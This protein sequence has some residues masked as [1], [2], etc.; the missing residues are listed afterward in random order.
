MILEVLM[1]TYLPWLMADIVDVGIA[2]RDFDYVLKMGG[3]MVIIAIIGV[4]GGIGGIIFSTLAGQYFGRDVRSALFNKVQALSFS[5]LDKF[6]KASIVTRLTNDVIQVQ[7][8]VMTIILS[9]MVRASLLIIGGIVMAYKLNKELAFI[10]WFIIPLIVFIMIVIIKKGIPLF[11][12]SQEKLDQLNL[13]V[14]ENLAGVRVVKVFMGETKEKEKFGVANKNLKEI[15]IKTFK[16]AIVLSPVSMTIMNLSIVAVLWFGGI[17]VSGGSVSVGVIMAYINYLTQILI[18]VT[19]LCNMIVSIS[20]GKVSADR[21]NEILDTKIDIIN[22]ETPVDKV[23]A[24]GEVE[25]ENVMFRY[26]ESTGNPVLINISL[27]VKRGETVG[28]LG[29]TGAGKTSLVSL[30]PRL[31]DVAEG[32]VLVNGLDVREYD[33]EDL[34]KRIGFVLQQSILFTGTIKENIKWGNPDA[35]DD[36]VEAAAR[37]AQCHDFIAQQ[38]N[39]YNTII[40]QSGVNL[41]G[42]QKQ[43]I[44]IARALLKKP[45]ILILDDST[46][47]LDT[48]TEA[49]LQKAICDGLGNCTKFIITQ[50]ISSIIKADKIILLE[51]GAIIA[52]GSHQHLLD[53]SVVYRE[54]YSSQKKEKVIV[55]E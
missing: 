17:S 39:G 38:E 13:V 10:F 7:Q 26:P 9:M 25:F 54:I 19:M 23:T 1:D 31:F 34:R 51:G 32:T 42:G 2:N 53:T 36:E 45:E 44:A 37:I 52:I 27:S 43:R 47:A 24:H 40:K 8:I 48:E 3:Y 33:L 4:L 35:T 46:S 49:K 18:A 30:I 5:N 22:P 28:I 15:N 14:R 20:R 16:V 11:I 41:S 21:I 55:H 29:Q 50:R 6:S 12:A